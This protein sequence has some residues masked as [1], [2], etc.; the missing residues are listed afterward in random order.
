MLQRICSI[1]TV[2]YVTLISGKLVNLVQKSHDLATV[3]A[4]CHHDNE[5][6]RLHILYFHTDQV[7]KRFNHHNRSYDC[8]LLSLVPVFFKQCGFLNGYF[9]IY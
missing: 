7:S 6:K 1:E 3:S 4:L 5:D 9:W 8:L 2:F